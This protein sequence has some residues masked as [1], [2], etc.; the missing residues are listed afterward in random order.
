LDT[1]LKENTH[2]RRAK[3]GLEH[4]LKVI[5]ESFDQASNLIAELKGKDSLTIVDR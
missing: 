2:L 1:A 4:E 3:A 5:K